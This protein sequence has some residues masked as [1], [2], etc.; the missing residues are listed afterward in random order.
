MPRLEHT[1]VPA[2]I[3]VP[4]REVAPDTTGT[5]YLLVGVGHPGVRQ[6]TA[7]LAALA[8]REVVPV[9]GADLGAVAGSFAAAL[10]VA[11][12]GVRLRLAGPVAACLA[13]RARALAAGVEDDELMVL[14]TG[15]ESI[16]LW[17]SHCGVV[18]AVAAGIDDVVPCAGCD[19][20]LLVYHHVSRRTGHFLGF[21]VDAEEAGALPIPDEL[22]S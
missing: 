10:G 1:S 8:G 16:D 11:R 22:A 18:S 14:P 19:R 3:A 20:N 6:V 2:W 17:C 12:V 7:W 21:Q 13:L 5:S 4:P 15:A 9:T